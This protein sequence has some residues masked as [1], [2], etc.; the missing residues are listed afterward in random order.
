[1]R[2]RSRGAGTCR[3]TPTCRNAERSATP[4]TTTCP[5]P[6]AA[7]ATTHSAARFTGS[8]RNPS[9]LPSSAPI[10]T[11]PSHSGKHRGSVPVACS[12]PARP[13]SELIQ[14]KATDV[15]LASRVGIQRAN[16]SS[17][18]RKIA[19]PVP[20]RPDST[21]IAAPTSRPGNHGTLRPATS[22]SI[23]A[24]RDALRNTP[25]RGDQQHQ[26]EQQRVTVLRQLDLRGEERRGRRRQHERQHV[27]PAHVAA[28][29]PAEQSDAADQQVE[30]ERGRTHRIRAR[31]RAGPSP[32]C[33]RSRRHGRRRNRGRR[34]GRRVRR[35]AGRFRSWTMLFGSDV[36][37][38][39]PVML[40]LQL[41]QRNFQVAHAVVFGSGNAPRAGSPATPAAAV[42]APAAWRRGWCGWRRIRFVDPRTQVDVVALLFAQVVS[43]PAAAA[44][45]VVVADEDAHV[46][47]EFREQP[48]GSSDT[49]WRHRHRENHSVHCRRRA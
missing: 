23:T 11:M 30:R 7:P 25:M 18:V 46:V 17:G 49:T 47:G 43:L 39:G 1:M 16:S 4:R 22:A 6:P 8:Q 2:P 40:R 36:S 3:A 5:R 27:A 20:V 33:S 32:R 41:V 34:R 13:V 14:T 9:W 10:A 26:S 19:P 42:P 21:P 15:P 48:A 44:G 38:D 24:A 37:R 45:T 29:P 35:A 31:S 12:R 28:A